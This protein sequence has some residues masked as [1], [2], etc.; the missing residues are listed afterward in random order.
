MAEKTFVDGIFVKTIQTQYG[1]IDKL[2]Y[3]VEKFIEF[4]RKHA[5]KSEKNGRWYLNTDFLSTQAGKKY[6]ALDTFKPDT[7]KAQQQA[8]QASAP[9]QEAFPNA[10]GAVDDDCPFSPLVDIRF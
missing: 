6:M 7:N 5:Q 2:S 10:G 1:D 4:A 8:P 3:D 9:P